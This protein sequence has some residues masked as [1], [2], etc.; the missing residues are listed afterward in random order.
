LIRKK[1]PVLKHN[2]F[3][4]I[5]KN[6]AKYWVIIIIHVYIIYTCMYNFLWFKKIN[7]HIVYILYILYILNNKFIV[8]NVTII[9]FRVRV[10]KTFLK[11][12]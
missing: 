4:V 5:L 1:M 2:K 8:Y 3:N 6:N 9:R 11:F 12:N 7:G 10:W